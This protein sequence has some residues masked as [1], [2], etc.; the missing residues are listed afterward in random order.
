MKDYIK[1]MIEEQ[2]EL[3]EKINKA[4]AYARGNNIEEND[5]GRWRELSL[6]KAQIDAM[7]SYYRILTLRICEAE[8]RENGGDTNTISLD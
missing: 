3:V 8:K 1:R 6:L 2:G 5:E 4:E 7:N